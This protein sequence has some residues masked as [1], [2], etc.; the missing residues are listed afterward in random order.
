MMLQMLRQHAG[1]LDDA[2]QQQNA[3]A[4][5]LAAIHKEMTDL[6][7]TQWQPILAAF[8]QQLEVCHQHSIL[9][10]SLLTTFCH[11]CCKA[12]A[13]LISAVPVKPPCHSCIL[14]ITPNTLQTLEHCP[15]PYIALDVFHPA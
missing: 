4:A 1:T 9:A 8:D 13:F 5:E 14:P 7:I 11:I 10:F 15:F 2:R 12:T 3:L 6:Q